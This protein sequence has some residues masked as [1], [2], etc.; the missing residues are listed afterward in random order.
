[1]T[2]EPPLRRVA[3]CRCVK[4]GDN[5]TPERKRRLS[6][7]TRHRRTRRLFLPDNAQ[8]DKYRQR[9]RSHSRGV[10]NSRGST[11]GPQVMQREY[12]SLPSLSDLQ[13][14]QLKD[15][16]I[17]PLIQW[18]ENGERPSGKEVSSTS[19]ATHHYWLYWDAL[20][21]TEGVLFHKFAKRDGTGHHIQFVVP[22]SMKDVV[23]Y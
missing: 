16:D 5:P 13:G 22:R 8:S 12:W 15:P 21:L 18:K 2:G 7:T 17:A 19:P 4:V 20:F 14:K 23:L 10:E 11:S 3:V 1:M 9:L 6:R